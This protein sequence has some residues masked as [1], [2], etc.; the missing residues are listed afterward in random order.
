MI[1]DS[2]VTGRCGGSDLVCD[3]VTAMVVASTAMSTMSAIQEGQAAAAQAD[4]QSDV[5]LRN[6]E[7]SA[8]QT[9]EALE[10]QDRERRLRRGA[11]I[12]G[13]GASGVGT[14]SFG[15]ILSSSAIQEEM[16]LLNIKQQGLLQQQNFQSESDFAKMQG[17]QAKTASY[18]KAGTALLG[19]ASK[20]YG[21]QKG[22]PSYGSVGS[23]GSSTSYFPKT[24]TTVRWN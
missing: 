2:D 21:G 5:A 1:F 13:S 16:D 24:N 6:Q 11:A 8:Q 20:M 15:D 14:E 4:Y 18:M 17:K 7:I 12:A 22:V 19:G 23:Q 3:P 9:E 10:T